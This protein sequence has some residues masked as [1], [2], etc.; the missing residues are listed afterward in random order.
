MHKIF[1]FKG[2]TRNTDNLY[3]ADGECEELVN[4]HYHN[5]VLTPLSAPETKALLPHGYSAVYR[6]EQASTYLCVTAGDGSVHLFD[7]NFTPL[8]ATEDNTPTVMAPQCRNVKRI[9]F[10]GNIVCLFTDTAT[11]YA[12]F[13]TTHYNWLG[14]RPSMPSLSFKVTSQVH[15][16]TT[17]AAYMSGVVASGT[18]E[19]LYWYN[20]SA[21]YFDECVAK[22]NE[23]GFYID[24]VLF[25][26]AFRLFD[27]SYAYFSPIYYVDDRNCISGLSRDS[28]N[29]YSYPLTPNTQPSTYKVKVQG[30]KPTF[31][32]EDFDLT[33]WE[34]IIISVD[35]FT[36]GSVPGH[37]I[38]NDSSRIL[39][40]RDSTYT[41]AS[42]GYDRYEYKTSTEIYTDVASQQ[43]FYKVAEFDLK[44]KLV[45]E[46]KDVSLSNLALAT[47]LSDDSMSLMGRTAQYTYVFNGRLH[48]AN[49]YETF[50]KGYEG[51]CF[52]PPAM[53]AVNVSATVS[54]ELKTTTGVTVVKRDYDG[55]FLLGTTEDGYF[56]SPYIMY[57]DA[58]AVKMTFA[59]NIEGITYCKTFPLTRHKILDIAYYLHEDSDGISVSL[60]GDFAASASVTVLQPDTFKEF[61][62][63]VTGGYEL[64][65][66]DNG[67]WL[68]GDTVFATDSSSERSGNY[69]AFSI[70]GTVTVG[71]KLFVTLADSHETGRIEE[72]VDIEINSSWQQFDS[73]PFFEEQNCADI[74]G[75]V[76][77]VSEV[78]NP[79]YFPVK[80][81]YAPSRNNIVAVCSNTVA[82]SQGQFGQHPLYVFCDDGIWAMSTDSSG[83]IAYTASYPL[84]REVC[85]NASSV[86]GIDSGVVFITHKGAMLLNGGDITLLSAALEN[87]WEGI[88]QSDEAS[89]VS[90]MA[91][92]VSLQSVLRKDNFLE[93]ML[94]AHVGF[95]YSEREL[96]FS[97][98]C[99]TY[100]YLL[101]LDS[102]TWSKYTGVFSYISNSYP[103]FI[104][105]ISS[106][107]ET[108]VCT[109]NR[110][111]VDWNSVML[112]SRPLLCGTKLHKR[113]MQL[114]LHASV[115]PASSENSFNGLACYVLGSNDGKN[116]KLVSGSERHK[117]FRDMTFPYMPSQSYRYFSVAIIG[118]ISTD[119]TIA[120]VEM[121]IA[122]AWNNR[123]N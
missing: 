104:G 102:G 51:H 1:S 46:L 79:F 119:S 59:I 26:Y 70:R 14:E 76:M 37:K 99:Y 29:F 8:V 62:S 16:L 53:S 88:S 10:M 49:L 31:V 81:T 2:I 50:F 7:D 73:T 28:G 48:L 42:S 17:E 35:V 36:S 78:D 87:R 105:V 92:I 60:S 95:I 114:V 45:D 97:N 9:E 56:I 66:S 3:S 94:D 24:R 113:I 74:R 18:D 21:G 34:N 96:L 12:V 101:S 19:A 39:S 63:Y 54:T 22:L 65:L 91:A 68:Y 120:A 55:T 123:L 41:S 61:F 122:A 71:D 72:I 6:H 121:A 82:L 107:N 118:R 27:G 13:D 93:Y 117:N 116:Y 110:N 47:S 44:G 80:Q 90:R 38:V 83:A 109:F 32:F 108:N 5:G 11:M 112:V 58:R 43:L 86:K 84:S 115:I 20:A 25:R 75:N 40:R 69:G 23:R 111:R 57:P 15:E 33:A 67:V 98:P 64:T 100:S 89:I 77:K 30:F 106:E 85:V 103:H 4:L 52:V